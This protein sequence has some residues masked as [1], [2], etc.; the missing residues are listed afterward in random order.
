[1]TRPT[2]YI[3]GGEGRSEIPDL[4]RRQSCD[5][6]VER[7]T[8]G[9]YL[10]SAA[11]AVE[12]KTPTDLV[13]SLISGRLLDQL[14]RLSNAYEY[15]A[16]LIEGDSWE[17]NPRLKSPMLAR[18]YQ[19]ISLRP[20]LSTIYSPNAKMTARILA[21]IARAEQDERQALPPT[22]A[23]PARPRPRS[24]AD[25]LCALPGVGQTNAALLLTTFH[26]IAGVVE[27]TR[28]ELCETLGPKRGT[29]LYETLHQ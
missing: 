9:D 25:V 24:P 8:E 1:M 27:A 19:W 7:L 6:I 22:P 15:A 10:L 4:L 5:V 3:D 17:A 26:T 2:I 14:D 29:T 13:D 11:F 21:G 20:Y 12:R 28:Q 18:L 16:L 23:P